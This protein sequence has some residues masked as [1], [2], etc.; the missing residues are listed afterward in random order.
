MNILPIV[1]IYNADYITCAAYRT[2][3]SHHPDATVVLYDNSPTPINARHASPSLHYIHNA[4]NGGVSAA[5]NA[6]ADYSRRKGSYDY[7]LLLDQD[8]EFDSRYIHTLLHTI[9]TH[10]TAALI[11]PTINT[12]H[13]AAFS[14]TSKTGRK[15]SLPPGEYPL[16]N[17]R[18][19]NSGACVSLEAFVAAGGYNEQIKLDFADFDF[20][21]RL[22]TVAESFI[23][24]PSTAVQDFSNHETGKDKL[25][26]RFAHYIDGARRYRQSEHIGGEVLRHTLALTLRTRSV[27]FLTTYIKR[28]VL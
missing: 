8:T 14:P 26:S 6:G 24:A 19:V 5:Y 21:K 1:V 25:L 27:D 20:F 2:L 7:L 13:G 3:L 18:I 23:V 28:Y 17:Y 9:S 22:S 11:V 15:S 4:T 12:K 10:P 16:D